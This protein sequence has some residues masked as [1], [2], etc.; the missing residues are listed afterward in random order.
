MCLHRKWQP[1]AI[2]SPETLLEVYPPPKAEI[3]APEPYAAHRAALVYTND[4]A[5]F[6]DYQTKLIAAWQAAQCYQ[7]KDG[8]TCNITSNL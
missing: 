3:G 1:Q 4:D 7:Q 5:L 6:N 8:T 2:F